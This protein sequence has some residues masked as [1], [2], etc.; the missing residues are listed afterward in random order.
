LFVEYGL[1]AKDERPRLYVIS[2]ANGELQGYIAT[3]DA[4]KEGGYEV[5]NCLFAPVTGRL[6][7]AE[8]LRLLNLWDAQSAGS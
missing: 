1:A 6:F 5:T 8:T 3:E 7:V 2:L 4:V